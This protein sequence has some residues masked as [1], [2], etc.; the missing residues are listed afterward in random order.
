MLT[1][2][3]TVHYLVTAVSPEMIQYDYCCMMLFH[4][5]GCSTGFV[6]ECTRH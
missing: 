1:I 6:S 3:N 5:V 2:N 4:E